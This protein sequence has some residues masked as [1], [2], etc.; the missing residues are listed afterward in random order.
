[1]NSIVNQQLAKF[2]NIYKTLAREYRWSSSQLINIFT[3]LIYTLSDK[4]FDRLL[5]DK[6]HGLMKEN[7]GVFS[8]YRSYDKFFMSALLHTKFDN[9][10]ESFLR[11]LKYE[12]ALKEEGFSRG[13]Y[14]GLAAYILLTSVDS[15]AVPK[16]ISKAK[17]I[18]GRM[19]ERHFWLTGQDDYPLAVLLAASEEQA[20]SIENKV[21]GLFQRLHSSG[22][23]KTNSLQFL[24]HI[25]S[26]GNDSMEASVQ[27]C[28]SVV[29]FFKT[30]KIK[31]NSTHYGTVGL[32]ALM[33]NEQY[34][35]LEE[36]I[37][38]ID[39]LKST[40]EFKWTG[41]DMLLL[42]ASTIVTASSIENYKEHEEL[43]KTSLGLTIQA[44]IAAQ[45]AAMVASISAVTAAA[46]ASSSS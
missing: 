5:M 10:E 24:S 37:K 30:K 16:T 36:I 44:V 15:D 23:S 32:I 40:R 8:H 34:E 14:S 1:M 9:P 25:L 12:D 28:Q 26:L 35:L 33:F 41:R 38:V 11:L 39:Y 19:R 21:E 29:N 17:Q 4:D 45:T 3:A 46:A 20:E 27:R 7:T 43:L 31:I 2:E 18:Y 42:I 6:M 22:F 13:T